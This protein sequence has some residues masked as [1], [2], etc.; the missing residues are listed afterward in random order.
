M[1][2]SSDLRSLQQ[3]TGGSIAPILD[4]FEDQLHEH[5]ED[6][7]SEISDEE[8]DEFLAAHDEQ[9][10]EE[11]QD[12]YLFKKERLRRLRVQQQNFREQELQ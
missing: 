9:A 8:I 2:A 5:P 6:Q 11:P 3:K 4:L 10:D 1:S 12:L 7:D